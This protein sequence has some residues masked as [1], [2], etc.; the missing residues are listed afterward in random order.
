MSTFPILI[1]FLLHLHLDLSAQQIDP[2][3]SFQL[4]TYLHDHLVRLDIRA[5]EYT[6]FQDELLRPVHLVLHQW[7]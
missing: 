7:L 1:Y 6:A 4:L 5:K 3:H 2:F